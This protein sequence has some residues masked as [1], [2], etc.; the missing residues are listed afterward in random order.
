MKVI[1]FI[2]GFVGFAVVWVLV[3]GLFVLLLHP[4]LPG[5]APDPIGVDWVAIPG[6]FVGALAGHRVYQVI[7]REKATR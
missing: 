3:T 6:S 7:T 2:I 1:R 4:L 5:R